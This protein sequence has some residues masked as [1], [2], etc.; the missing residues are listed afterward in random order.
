MRAVPDLA[1]TPIMDPVLKEKGLEA[2]ADLAIPKFFDPMP[3]VTILSNTLVV[4]SKR[5]PQ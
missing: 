1:P 2:W 5:R 4:A 3:I